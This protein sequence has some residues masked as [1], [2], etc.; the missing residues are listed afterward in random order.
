[1]KKIEK[2][3]QKAGLRAGKFMLGLILAVMIGGLSVLPAFGQ[4]YGRPYPDDR[5]RYE[6]R[7]HDRGAYY[8]H[9]R[10]YRPYYAPPPVYA[11]PPI[12]YAPPPPPPG[13]SIFLPPIRIW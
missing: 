3:S 11:P 2:R 5:Y 4:Y 13:I 7:G 10:V 12:F 8:Y 1:M 6:Q 9:R